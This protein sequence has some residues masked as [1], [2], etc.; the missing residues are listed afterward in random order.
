MQ[1]VMIVMSSDESHAILK[2]IHFFFFYLEYEKRK[3]AVNIHN[4][5]VHFAPQVFVSNIYILYIWQQ[6]KV[7]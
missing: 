5:E 3:T 2:S 1:D 6:S 7:F 4:A